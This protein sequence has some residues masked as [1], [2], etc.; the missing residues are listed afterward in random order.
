MRFPNEL[1]EHA[2]Q[3]NSREV[4]YDLIH[5]LNSKESLS[6]SSEALEIDEKEQEEITIDIELPEKT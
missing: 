6:L 1:E 5:G 3:L 4:I 2:V